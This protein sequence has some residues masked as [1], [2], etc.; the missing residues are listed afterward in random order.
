MSY[1]F[2]TSCLFRFLWFTSALSKKKKLP[3]S[4]NQFTFLIPTLPPLVKRKTG[5]NTEVLW[6]V[7][8]LCFSFALFHQSTRA[9]HCPRG[10]FSSVSSFHQ[11]QLGGGGDATQIDFCAFCV[12]KGQ[13]QLG[14]Y[15][16]V[17]WH[18]CGSPAYRCHGRDWF[19]LFAKSHQVGLNLGASFG[20]AVWLVCSV[21]FEH[22]DWNP[23]SYR[24]LYVQCNL[25]GATCPLT[26]PTS[27]LGWWRKNVPA[28]LETCGSF[29]FRI[30][31]ISCRC[32]GG[33]VFPFGFNWWIDPTLNFCT[34]P[35]IK[36]LPAS[37]R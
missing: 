2:S 3:V 36:S 28:G 8:T 7:Q 35:L 34:W 23:R 33:M 16:G 4:Q 21:R 20:G 15:L 9:T 14:N 1:A 22:E 37:W 24:Y 32:A 12:G 6:S 13:N 17:G 19:P 11:D 18:V 30:Q 5:E 27:V 29:S 31:L 25:M 10:H 26:T